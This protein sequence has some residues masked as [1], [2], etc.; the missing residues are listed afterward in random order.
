MLNKIKNKS[1]IINKKEEEFNVF[2]CCKKEME[3]VELK[4]HLKEIH[5]I[6]LEKMAMSRSLMMHLNKGRFHQSTYK[7]KAGDLEFLQYINVDMRKIHKG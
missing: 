4:E 3:F 7:W 1:K 2:K 6:D 5:K